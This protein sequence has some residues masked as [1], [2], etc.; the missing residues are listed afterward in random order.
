MAQLG[1]VRCDA[2]S[3]RNATMNL[4]KQKLAR[5]FQIK[6][7]AHRS[8]LRGHIGL[9][10]CVWKSPRL[11]TGVHANCQP[12]G[13]LDQRHQSAAMALKSSSDLQLRKHHSH[14]TRRH[15]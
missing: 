2:H 1:F 6:K 14:D 7:R 5:L 12:S 15:L 4:N 10:S 9:Q 13:D 3:S 8:R 11:F